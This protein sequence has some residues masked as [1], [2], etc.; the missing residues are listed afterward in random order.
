MPYSSRQLRGAAVLRALSHPLRVSILEQLTVHGP[1]TATQLGDAIDESPAN[2][3]WH[4][5]KLAQHGLVV[6]AAAGTGRARPWQVVAQGLEW[7]SSSD[8]PDAA[9]AGEALT[10]MLID[11]AVDRLGAA[12]ARAGTEPEEWR[13]ATSLNQSIMWMT[14]QELEQVNRS[15]RDLFLAHVDRFEHPEERPEGARLCSLM[16]WGSPAY[17]LA[18]TSAEIDDRGARDRAEGSHDA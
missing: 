2:C 15:V 5:R 9:L 12:R 13:D 16:A 4:L 3:S 18:A 17:D 10:Q 1:M 8:T 11:R 7:E 14:A 6:E